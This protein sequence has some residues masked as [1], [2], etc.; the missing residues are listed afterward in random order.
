MNKAPQIRESDLKIVK[1]IIKEVLP[2]NTNIWV[3]GSRAK[4]K[5]RRASDLDLAIDLGRKLTKQEKSQLFHLFED[6]NLPYKVD[7]VDLQ[8][9]NENLKK[10]IDQDKIILQ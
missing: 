9:V 4:E 7:V 3:F 1:A 5:A 6:S 2:E 10:M 8:S